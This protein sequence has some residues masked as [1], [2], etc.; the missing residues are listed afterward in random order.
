VCLK[1]CFVSSYPPNRA[2]LS[3]YAKNLVA[4]LENR[5]S[6]SK[7]FVLGDKSAATAADY[8]ADSK[9]EVRR[10]WTP[11]DPVS[12]LNILR[13]ILKLRPDVVHYNVHFQSYGRGRIANF[14]G[15]SLIFLSRLLG[16]KVLAEVHNLGEKVDLKKV[17]LKP[18]FL[19][20][21]GIFLA[22]KLILSAH[23][24]VVTVK[25]YVDYLSQRYGH[26]DVMYIPHGTFSTRCSYVDPDEKVILMFGHMGPYKGL[27]VMFEAFKELKAEGKTV[28]L[29]IAGTS[30]PNYPNFLDQF[31]NAGI[32]DVEFLGYVSEDNL[33]QLFV[34]ADVVVL[35]YSTTTGTSGV[36]HLAAGF[37]RPIVASSLPEIKELVADGAA[38]MLV[39]PGDVTALKAALVTVLGDEKLACA[40]SE[41]NLR[42]ANQESWSVVAQAYENA[43][44]RLVHS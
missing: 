38:A 37:G 9:V 8:L 1:V 5:Q 29:I 26:N 42:F 10:V 32:P 25:S 17:R 13:H 15:L 21:T 36:F 43:Y 39:P 33:E 20:R 23:N 34:H 31:I 16:F 22:T 11:D 6:I 35:P 30:H 40:M 3:E 24:V 27:P 28:K 4:E 19:N 18:S 7:I 44:L 14:L 2:R 12:I 41:Q